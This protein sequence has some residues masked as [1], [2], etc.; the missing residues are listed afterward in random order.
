MAFT[1]DGDRLL[2]ACW[3]G[4]VKTWDVA[5]GKETSSFR[6][7][8]QFG[9]CCRFS[10]DARRLAWT[11][12]DGIV[13]V[14]DIATEQNST[15]RAT[16]TGAAPSLS[17]RTASGSSAGPSNP[18]QEAGQL[19]KQYVDSK[20]EDEKRE[21]RKKLTDVLTQQ[22][23]Q[24][25]QEQQ[26]ELEDLEKQIASLKA[27]LTKRKEAK[28]TIVERRIEQLIQDAEGLGWNA[29]GSSGG[30]RVGPPYGPTGSVPAYGRPTANPSKTPRES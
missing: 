26:K 22:F 19:A 15:C 18:Y 23:D 3:D 27:V 21:I 5:T 30:G 13:K 14:W 1:P 8:F 2:S 28:S 16:C 12:T 11:C 4:T 6:G 17:A 9:N 20:K 10:P 24:Q 25:I 7:Q 29:P